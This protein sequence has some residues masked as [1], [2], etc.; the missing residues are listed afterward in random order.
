MKE[1]IN[2]IISA[3]LIVVLLICAA[4]LSGIAELDFLSIGANAVT[5]IAKGRC[6][7]NVTYTL[8]YDNGLV[9][10]EGEGQMYIFGAT[11]P[12]GY[13]YYSPF[14]NNKSI[15]KVVIKEGITSIGSGAFAGCTSLQNIEI[16][17]SLVR[18]GR[19]AFSGCVKLESLHIPANVSDIEYDAFKNC[20][21]LQSITV[22]EDNKVYDSRENCNA[23]I[24][25]KRNSIFVGSNNTV[26][27]NGIDG[28]ESEA[29][30]NRKGITAIDLPESLTF[31]G[32]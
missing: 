12:E 32:E 3:L 11:D 21:G 19:T 4:P 24:R 26:I 10:I 15:L 22:D 1:K 9:T 30:Y 28:I 25:T 8:D 29:F 13:V 17:Q 7:E 2:K 27:P 6:G 23:L 16:A 14:S 31:M 5:G 20:N 18:I